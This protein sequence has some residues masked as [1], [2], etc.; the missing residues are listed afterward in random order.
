MEK[1]VQESGPRVRK[2][3]NRILVAFLLNLIFTFVEVWGS[4]L[5]GSVTILSDAIHDFGDCIALGMAWRMEKLSKRP[6]NVRYTFGYGRFSVVAGLVNNLILLMGGVV[7]IVTS[8]QRFFYPRAIDGRGML[9]FAVFGILLNGTAMLLTAKGKNINEKTISM[10]M[11]EDVL[12]WVAVLI[13]GIV[14]CIYPLPILDSLLS[15]GMTLVIFVGVAK[16][17]KRILGVLT[18][19]CP[20]TE[21]EYRRL[22][23][24]LDALNEFGGVEALRL[25]SMDGED[26][27]AEVYMVFYEEIGTDDGIV[28]F[29]EV[30]E[31]CKKSGI[32][33]TVIQFRYEINLTEENPG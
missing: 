29:S 15:I 3:E 25:Y 1:K 19:R 28:L 22:W 9:L 4:M 33:E 14:M 5:T 26:K 13:V 6:A 20:L 27:R 2:S 8:L 16:N 10:H 31:C 12:T 18:V 32:S 23:E 21:Q 7:L 11:L 24:Q 17:L 30:G